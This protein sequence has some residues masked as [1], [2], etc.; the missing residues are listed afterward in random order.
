MKF[1]KSLLALS[2]IALASCSDSDDDTKPT[3]LTG[4]FIDSA[5]QGLSYNSASTSGTTGEDGSF[6]AAE[7]LPAPLHFV[8][9]D[10]PQLGVALGLGFDAVST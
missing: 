3:T 7:R 10:P 8:T 6:A 4:F 5:V 2:I 1:T 9:F